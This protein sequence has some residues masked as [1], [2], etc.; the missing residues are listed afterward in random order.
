[1][2][3]GRGEE[4]PLCDPG[5]E[6]LLAGSAKARTINGMKKKKNVAK[7]FEY[8]IKHPYPVPGIFNFY[9]PILLGAKS[10]LH[11]TFFGAVVH[12]GRIY[13]IV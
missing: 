5:S 4:G 11:I 7:V 10:Y 6:L 9:L 3:G 12:P 1:M 13:T 2:V 8:H